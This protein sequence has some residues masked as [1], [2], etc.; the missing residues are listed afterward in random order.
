M[1]DK[2]LNFMGL[3]FNEIAEKRKYFKGFERGIMINGEDIEEEM[4]YFCCVMDYFYER[5]NLVSFSSYRAFCTSLDSYLYSVLYLIKGGS[6]RGLIGFHPGRLFCYTCDLGSDETFY[7][8][9]QFYRDEWAIK[10][11]ETD[12]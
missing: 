10:K 9:N 2:Y 7:L 5:Y 11:G 1:T 6:V 3:D 12:E 8:L 4:F